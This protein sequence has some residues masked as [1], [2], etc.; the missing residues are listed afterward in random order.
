MDINVFW[1]SPSP[2]VGVYETFPLEDD[3]DILLQID[4]PPR[5]DFPPSILAKTTL[6]LIVIK[7]RYREID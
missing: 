1:Y 3:D 4:C 6:A 7:N 2:A 5:P